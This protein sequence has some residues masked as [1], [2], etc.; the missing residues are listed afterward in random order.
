VLLA[1][2]ALDGADR[3]GGLLSGADGDAL[4]SAL[5]A[6]GYAP[7]EWAGLSTT[8]AEG[9]TLAPDLLRLA[10]CT[11]DPA[12]LIACDEAAAQALRDAYADE[13]VDVADLAC[14]TLEE[15]YV[16]DILGMRVMNLGEFASSLSDERAK[17][18]MWARLKQVP[19]LGEPF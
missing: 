4:R 5:V 10:V 11:L 19:P 8:D 9:G 14:A 3:E 2:G 17:Q 1:K 6:L 16:V 15:G 12:T 13:L 7:Q 18:L